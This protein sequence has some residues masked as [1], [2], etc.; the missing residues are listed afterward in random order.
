MDPEKAPSYS[1]MRSALLWKDYDFLLFLFVISTIFSHDFMRSALLWKDYDRFRFYLPLAT[2]SQKGF[3]RSALLWKDYDLLFDIRR[4]FSLFSLW[5]LPCFERITT[6][7][8]SVFSFFGLAI[9]I[10]TL[11]DLPCFERITTS[12]KYIPTIFAC[13]KNFMRSALLWKDYDF[14]FYFK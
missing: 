7:F 8:N 12:F 4:I 1:F 5:D 9:F 6:S 13:L 11:W 10:S 2:D 3:M 14:T